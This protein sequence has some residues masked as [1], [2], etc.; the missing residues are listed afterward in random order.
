MVVDD[1][2]F[3]KL[4]ISVPDTLLREHATI[5]VDSLAPLEIN[6]SAGGSAWPGGACFGL[7]THGALTVLRRTDRVLVLGY[8][9]TIQMTSPHH[10]VCRE[11][12]LADTLTF[13]LRRFDQLSTWL[14]RAGPGPYAETYP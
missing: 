12:A 6:Y 2:V 9:L 7:A 3:A 1:E 8:V 4:T 10:R 5:T 11:T 13:H 14:G